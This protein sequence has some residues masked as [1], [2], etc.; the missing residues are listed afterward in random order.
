[1]SQPIFQ[2]GNRKI[3]GD[4]PAYLI[5][6]LSANHGQS[7][8]LAKRL[9]HAAAD[10]GADAV[11]LQTY[12]AD[13]LTLNCDNS[14]FQINHNTDWDGQNFHSLY[15]QAH[16]PWDWQPKLKSFANGLGLELFSS[17]FDST[18]IDFLEEMEVPAYK[19]A[20]FEIVD[21]PLLEHVAKT[22]RPTILSTGMATL[23]EIELAVT[24]L[25]ENGCRQ[26]ALL[27]CT[28]AYPAPVES[29]NL[30]TIPVMA[31][32]FQVPVGLSDHT[33]GNEAAIAAVCLGGCIV[34]KHLTLCRSDGGP[35]SSFSLEPSEFREMASTIRRVERAMGLV[36][37]GPNSH[38][39]EN[40]DFRRSLFVVADIKQGDAFTEANIRSIRPGMGL[41]P[42]NMRQIIGKT[43]QTDIRRGTPLG[44]E[45]IA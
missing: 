17:P 10:A 5:A 11:K 1:M 13:T 6:E 26:I 24:T 42:K 34:E 14:F 25:R 37:F 12:T 3:G 2:I 38:D 39:V 18:A 45:H 21:I 28:S 43:A 29:M 7:I 31:E 40:T 15:Q 4:Q 23:E 19:I 27:K 35:D 16:M 36:H 22:G 33:L 30:K 44:W 32:H 20:S 9:I 8:D 41:A